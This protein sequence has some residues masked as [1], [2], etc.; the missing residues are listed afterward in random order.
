MIEFGLRVNVLAADR[1][2][3]R[4]RGYVAEAQG[5]GTRSVASLLSDLQ[6]AATAG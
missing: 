1:N 6:S 4:A 3:L 5:V 2:F